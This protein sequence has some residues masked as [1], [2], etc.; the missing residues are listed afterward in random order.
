MLPHLYVGS[1][2]GVNGNLFLKGKWV[3]DLAKSV[4]LFVMV[5]ISDMPTIKYGN[6][7]KN[8]TGC[9]KDDIPK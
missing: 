5:S 4:E 9:T 7:L 6:H 2:K 1:Y 3:V 8:D